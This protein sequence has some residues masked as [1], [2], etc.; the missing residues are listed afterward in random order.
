M[1]HRT[2]PDFF[3]F[4]QTDEHCCKWAPIIWQ[5]KTGT[6]L[7]ATD[8]DLA[9]LKDDSVWWR[10]PM[11]LRDDEIVFCLAS[12]AFKDSPGGCHFVSKRGVTHHSGCKAFFACKGQFVGKDSA[13]Q[14]CNYAHEAIPKM[15][16]KGES[17]NWGWD[18]HYKNFTLTFKSLM[19]GRRLV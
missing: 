13:R 2:M 11:F 19:S 3:N 15:Q 17:Q 18:K 6:V 12:I 4:A 1:P 5:D 9:S 10:T 16:Y 7:G 14:E 8:H